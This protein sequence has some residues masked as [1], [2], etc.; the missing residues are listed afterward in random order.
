MKNIVALISLLVSTT[1]FA[2]IDLGKIEKSIECAVL[3]DSAKKN[4]ARSL[5][6]SD[7]DLKANGLSKELLNFLIKEDD[8]NYVINAKE[9]ASAIKIANQKEGEAMDAMLKKYNTKVQTLATTNFSE[10]FA[11]LQTRDKKCK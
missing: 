8:K 7:D 10:F 1:T 5:Q 3:Y 2:A 6:R 4:T 9:Y 11:Y